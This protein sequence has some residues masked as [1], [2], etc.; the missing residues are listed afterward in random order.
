MNHP[1]LEYISP[2]GRC[3]RVEKIWKNA[4]NQEIKV[5]KNRRAE[6]QTLIIY[7]NTQF[8]I[9]CNTLSISWFVSDGERE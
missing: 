8:K 1:I 2:P 3:L 4:G 7:E 9:H 6:K 5:Q